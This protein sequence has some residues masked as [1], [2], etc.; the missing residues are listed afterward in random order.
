MTKTELDHRL[1]PNLQGAEAE[2]HRELIVRAWLKESLMYDLALSNL[3]NKA[4]IDMLVESYRR[5]LVAHQYQEQLI[6]EQMAGRISEEDVRGFYDDNQRLFKL[7][8]TLV[9]GLF[10]KIP[11]DAPEINKIKEWYKSSSINDI[12]K[13]EK[14]S[15]KNAVNYDYFYDR[16][17]SVEEIA[18]SFPANWGDPEAQV[19]RGRQVE[20]RDSAFFYLLNIRQI[21]YKGDTQ[22]YE[23]AR[24]KARSMIVNQ[25]RMDF[26]RAFEEDL[27]RQAE[28]KGIIERRK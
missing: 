22:P 9:K 24:E 20:E 4:E 28:A 12:E 15:L 26:L 10:L 23:Y 7:D 25:R 13:I 21:M 14:Y 27:Y 17:V 6:E 18:R 19:R 1:P 5:S 2:E 11:V 16:W 8:A 3:Y